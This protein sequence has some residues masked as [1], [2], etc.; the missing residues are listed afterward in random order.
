M[1]IVSFAHLSRDV[2]WHNSPDDNLSRLPKPGYVP[3]SE[4]EF[5]LG[6]TSPSPATSTITKTDDDRFSYCI[7]VFQSANREYGG[8]L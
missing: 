2:D 4:F 3:R 7:G 5:T 8:P 6:R 1:V